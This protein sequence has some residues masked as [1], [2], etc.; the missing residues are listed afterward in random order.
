MHWTKGATMDDA[1]PSHGTHRICTLIVLAVAALYAE[2]SIAQ[3]RDENAAHSLLLEA[4]D[5]LGG[6]EQIRGV[7]R[8]QLYGF[9][10]EADGFG[11]GNV[12]G[13][14]YAP[15]KWGAQNDLQRVW[16]L[17]NGRYMERQ[18]GDLLFPFANSGAHAFT[19]V[20][21]VLD[22]DIAYQI[23]G[24]FGENNSEPRRIGDADELRMLSLAHPLVAVRAALEEGATLNNVHVEDGASVFDVELAS[25]E[26]LTIGFEWDTDL[27]A[28]V[29]WS[30]PNHLLGEVRYTARFTGYVPYDGIQL[31]LGIV[32]YMDWRDIEFF[33]I[34]GEGYIVNGRIPDLRAPESVR[35]PAPQPP[36]RQLEV[37]EVADGIWRI[38]NGTSVIEFADHLTLYEL[39]GFGYDDV[40]LPVIEL[41][42]SLVPSKP[43]T[44]LIVSHQ[45]D[46]HAS[47]LRT[48]VA[49]ELTIV[50]HR[51]NEQIFREIV[52]RPAPNFPDL[53]HRNPKP[54]KFVGV[55]DRLRLQDSE[56]TLD[57]YHVIGHNH[58]ANAIFAHDPDL[59]VIVEADLGTY[60]EDLLWWADAYIQNVE[61]YDLDVDVISPVHFYVMTHDELLRFIE[62]GRI[63]AQQ[64]CVDQAERGRYIVGCPP[65]LPRGN[66][67]DEL[68]ELF[69]PPYE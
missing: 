38:S 55:D 17:E 25:G 50:G 58:M 28:F 34:Y 48:A 57:L 16:D 37:A 5:A 54:L 63:R 27:P 9:G 20:R 24:G 7:R 26:E 46:D 60:A 30:G 14:P 10:Q 11:S 44:E 6:L 56:R 8:L 52:S 41:A 45:H 43:V 19:L 35:G 15:Q 65:F 42:R 40:S 2:A 29:R 39:G 53:L 33:K 59:R 1:S 66:V 32:I 4:A 64:R 13:S 67:I 69:D 12:A 47:G 36:E 23:G 3:Q 21:R 31:P 49:E 62:P 61:H 68:N 51:G 18:R 22:G